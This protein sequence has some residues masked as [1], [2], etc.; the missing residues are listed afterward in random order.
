MRRLKGEELVPSVSQLDHIL[1][2]DQAKVTLVQYGDYECPYTISSHWQMELL[3]KNF[4]QEFRFVFRH[5]PLV[6]RHRFA[7]R[8]AEAVEAAGAQGKFW[9]MHRALLKQEYTLGWEGIRDAAKALRL[10]L[11]RF[12]AEVLNHFYRSAIQQQI[13]GGIRSGVAS[14]PA[15]FLNGAFYDGPD[16]YDDFVALIGKITERS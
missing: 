10:D 4:P 6:K 1:G 13:S 8:A 2:R 14:T 11:E 12:E 15:Y 5:F 7:L 3:L 9:E 16:N